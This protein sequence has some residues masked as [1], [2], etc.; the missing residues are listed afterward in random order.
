MSL[1]AL[2][3][4]PVTIVSRSYAGEEIDDYGNDVATETSLTVSGYLQQLTGNEREG[5][6]PEAT[7]L[8]VLPANTAIQANDQVLD[9]FSREYQVLGPPANVWNPRTQQAH[10]I[11]ATLRRIVSHEESS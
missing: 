3:N 8:L 4:Q 1:E 10:H 2:M 7:D 6:V 11:E 5:Y 9:S